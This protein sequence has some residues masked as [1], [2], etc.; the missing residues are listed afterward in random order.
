MM[1]INLKKIKILEPKIKIT[2]GF[3]TIA[4]EP[5]S[6]EN[7]AKSAIGIEA[8]AGVHILGNAEYTDPTFYTEEG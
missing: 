3:K 2:T 8:L 1:N 5:H 4:R 6:G 7:E